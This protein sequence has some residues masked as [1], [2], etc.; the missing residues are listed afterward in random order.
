MLENVGNALG[1]WT[2]RN[3]KSLIINGAL[4]ESTTQIT[5]C[6]HRG[7]YYLGL[8]LCGGKRNHAR[9]PVAAGRR[10]PPHKRYAG[11]C[12]DIE[13]ISSLGK[14]REERPVEDGILFTLRRGGQ[15][16]SFF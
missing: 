4:I 15:S 2:G 11:P 9:L 8:Q 16:D 7:Q 13:R 14:S 6:H 12:L 10:L 5:H 1:I 3:L